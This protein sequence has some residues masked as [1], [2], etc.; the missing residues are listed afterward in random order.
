MIKFFKIDCIT[1]LHVGSGDVNYNIVDNEVEKDPITGYPIIHASGVKGALREHFSDN[2]LSS[3]EIDRIFGKSGDD[4]ADGGFG[5]GSYK[6]MDAYMLARSL[7][8]ESDVYACLPVLS[9]PM[10]NQLISLF[11][12]FGKPTNQGMLIDSIS[13]ADAKSGKKCEFMVS[14]DNVD[15]VEGEATGIL[16]G[17]DKKKLAFLEPII[18]KNFAIARNINSYDLPVIARNC[19]EEGKENL[20][21]EEIVPRGSIFFFAIRTPDSDSKFALLFDRVVQFGA[22]SSIG[23]GFCRISEL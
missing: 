22:H 9:I 13:F 7:R 10:I 6:F 15:S 19:L 4:K 3:T 12:A 16:S 11:T 2:R 1:N 18:G 8:V 17:A 5:A 20:W 23:R 21:Y 14:C